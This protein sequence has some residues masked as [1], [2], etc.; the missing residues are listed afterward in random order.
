L[1]VYRLSIHKDKIT[2]IGKKKHEETTFLP[3]G[4]V[5]GRG[6]E[7]E[8]IRRVPFLSSLRDELEALPS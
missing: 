8:E 6:S 2:E 1:F 7:S 3:N 5:W 4:M